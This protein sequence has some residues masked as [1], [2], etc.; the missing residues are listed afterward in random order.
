MNKIRELLKL[1]NRFKKLSLPKRIHLPN[2]M[3]RRISEDIATADTFNAKVEFLP[4]HMLICQTKN[5]RIKFHYSLKQLAHKRL[6]VVKEYFKFL[7]SNYA[8][9]DLDFAIYYADS[10]EGVPSSISLPTF[11]FAKHNESKGPILIPDFEMLMGYETLNTQLERY[12]KDVPWEK[13]QACSFW[14]GATTGGFP[15]RLNYHT[16]PRIKLALIS[17]KYPELIDA[18]ISQIV[19][20]E[21]NVFELFEAEGLMGSFSPVSK[22]FNYK[23]LIDIDGNTCTY[24]RLYWIL[25]SNCVPVKQ[26]SP[27]I[28]WYYYGLIDLENVCFF[29]LDSIGPDSLI[30]K[31]KFLIHN[32]QKAKEIARNSRS[33]CQRFLNYSYATNYILSALSAIKQ[34]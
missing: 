4:D 2:W 7:S 12:A 18:R 26:I 23:Y 6:H 30:S 28:Q 33:F 20:A 16:I 19:Q 3:H 24:S 11:A 22:H 9:P 10:L 32:D 5:Q 29:S 21:D 8:L 27:N 15:T 14:R 31:L 1:K 13:K 25:Y 17:L 34:N